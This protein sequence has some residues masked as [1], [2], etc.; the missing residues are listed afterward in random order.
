M[1][2]ETND[3]VLP[4]GQKPEGE[5]DA[6]KKLEDTMNGLMKN[7]DLLQANLKRLTEENKKL[8]DLVGVIDDASAQGRELI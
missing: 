3:N 1:T 8:K 5:L 7:I 2:I 6:L 4:L